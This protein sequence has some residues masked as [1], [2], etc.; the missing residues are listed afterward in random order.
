M[1][2]SALSLRFTTGL[3]LGI[4]AVALAACGDQ[5]SGTDPGGTGGVA[6]SGGSSSGTG[7][8]SAGGSGASGSGS[9]AGGFGTGGQGSGGQGT[10][11]VGSGGQ[12]AGG[13]GA[14]GSSTGGTSGGGA[15]GSAAGGTSGAGGSNGGAGGSGG[16]EP[17][18]GENSIA[19]SGC[20]MANNIGTGY[21]RVGGKIMWNADNY[22]TGAMIVQNWTSANSSSWQLFDQKMQSI[23][24]KDTVKAIMVQ[25]CVGSQRAT[26][27]ELRDMVA[28][29]RQHVNPGTHIYIVGQPV[30][31][32]GHECFIAGDGG[33]DWTD[34]KAK[35]LAAD[36]TVNQDMTYLGKFI[37]DDT[38]GEVAASGDTCHATSPVGEDSLGNQAKAYWGG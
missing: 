4:A 11:G 36:A 37:L 15:G 5:G 27:K 34:E 14:G 22:Q 25:I 17:P 1:T 31:N 9:G 33:A 3:A 24:G 21:K 28:S 8:V 10:G 2:L 7:G 38:K 19:Y 29:A 12:G 23:G 20:S 16:F 30:Y 18:T 32:D 35:E 26:D 13:L 6:G